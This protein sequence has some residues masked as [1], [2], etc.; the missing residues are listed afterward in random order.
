MTD[1]TNLDENAFDFDAMKEAVG[2]D[3][4]AQDTKKYAKIV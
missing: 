4:F 2:V 1:M 3:P